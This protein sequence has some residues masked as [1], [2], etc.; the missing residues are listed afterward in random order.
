MPLVKYDPAGILV[1]IAA[2]LNTAERFRER[3]QVLGG[4]VQGKAW[5]SKKPVT[6]CELRVQIYE[7]RVQIYGLR[8]QI[9][10]LRVQIYELRVQIYELQV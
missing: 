8:V 10:G 6:S 7:L 3:L 1:S 2:G 4:R 5:K 9:Y